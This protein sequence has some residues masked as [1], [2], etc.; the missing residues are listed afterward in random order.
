[1][2]NAPLSRRS[3]SLTP[4]GNAP[5]PPAAEAPRAP[6]ASIVP[7]TR[8]RARRHPLPTAVRRHATRTVNI[9]PRRPHPIRVVAEQPER[10]ITFVAKQPAHSLRRVAVV[11]TQL[12]TR[13]PPADGADAV[14]LPQHPLV[15]LRDEAV[16]PPAPC[17]PPLAKSRIRLPLLAPQR[18]E[19]L[20][21]FRT[22]GATSRELPRSMLRVLGISSPVLL[23]GES[24]SRVPEFRIRS[25][26]AA[27]CTQ[28]P[29]GSR[30]GRT[31]R[32][33]GKPYCR[34]VRKRCAGGPAGCRNARRR[35]CRNDLDAI[36]N[37]A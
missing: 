30:R 21:A 23:V 11:D 37:D 8:R 24:Q 29:P 18:V 10:G 20:A 28:K 31:A 14:L 15:I 9:R 26:G 19:L 32:E 34:A 16:C 36:V 33:Q 13:F 17:T 2:P 22:V 5:L 4:P 1:M 35:R 6:A 7:R 25:F 12:P 3:R 27:R